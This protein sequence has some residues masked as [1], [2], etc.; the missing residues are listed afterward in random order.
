MG[1]S[2]DQIRERLEVIHAEVSTLGPMLIGSLLKKR[3]R[4]TRKDGSEYI[5]PPYYTL[6]YADAK[7]R[8]C[9]KRVPR[10]HKTQAQRLIKTGINYRAL[11][12]EYSFLSNELA[13][14]SALKKTP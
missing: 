3:N 14:Q 13:Q 2:I 8:R 1:L 9:W 10:K 4:K 5:S 6:Q 7:G 11:E 12:R